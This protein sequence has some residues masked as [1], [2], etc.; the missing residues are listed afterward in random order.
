MS[1]FRV[2]KVTSRDGSAGPHITGV[3]TFT[4][5]HG[6]NIPSGTS[7]NR[8][9]PINI[10][11]GGLV[12]YVDG[13]QSRLGDVSVHPHIIN[14]LSPTGI[15]GD[16][17]GGLYN[18]DAAGSFVFD[19]SNDYATFDFDYNLDSFTAACWVKLDD[20]T[21]VETCFSYGESRVADK[22]PF[23][24]RVQHKGMQFWY[25][26]DDDEDFRI[27]SAG[28]GGG[29]DTDDRGVGISTSEISTGTWTFLAAQWD[30]DP[31]YQKFHMGTSAY[32][33][34]YSNS[35]TRRKRPCSVKG[36]GRLMLG[37][38]ENQGGSIQDYWGGEVGMACIYDFCLN[39]TQLTQLYND[40][41][42]RFGY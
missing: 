20:N 42:T 37:A 23:I 1:V 31:M 14:D 12:F 28:V 41:K 24:L 30:N 18:D 32:N 22:N 11:S 21:A 6:I 29:S 2:D 34:L 27:A 3:T 9:G 26:A 35:K 7:G 4:G 13:M 10:S 40:T 19:G 38:R 15:T 16:N 17:V 8:G 33:N 39:D 5:T 25:E 36:D